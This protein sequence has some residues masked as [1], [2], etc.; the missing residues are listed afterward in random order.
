M[1]PRLSFFNRRN[2]HLWYSW[3]QAKRS[4]LPVSEEV[5][6]KTYD[7]HFATLTKVDPVDFNIM[8]EIFDDPCFKYLL[9]K[10]RKNMMK[11]LDGM[12]PFEEMS[13]SNSACFEQTRGAGGQHSELEELCGRCVNSSLS[14]E[15][16]SM[17][18]D[19]VV[20]SHGK[21]RHNVVREN[22][23]PCGRDEWEELS[24]LAGAW[25]FT[26][27]VNCTIQAVLEPFKVRVIS[28]G[29]A[30]P[31]YSCRPLQKA[32]HGALKRLD[33]FRLIGR[34][35][36]PTDM[37]DLK[38]K[39][40][41]GDQWFS[42]D[43]SAATD[44]LSWIYSGRIL[45]SL[46]KDLPDRDQE[47]A[48]SVLGP[49]ALHYPSRN[50][51]TRVF[52][53]VQ[54]NGQLMGSILSFPILCLANVGV[55]LAVTRDSQRG[56][57]FRD[58]LRHVLVNG[59]DMLYSAHPD[60]WAK[61]VQYGKGVGLEMSVG[62]AYC[63]REY[64]NI[65]STSIHYS[66]ERD[67]DVPFQINYLNSGLFY[68]QHKVQGKIDHRENDGG[69]EGDAELSC[70]HASSD[71]VRYL[72]AQSHHEPG[73]TEGLAVNLNTV[74][75]G[76][77]PGREARLL[78]SFLTTHKD[79]LRKECAIVAK[80]GRKTHLVTRN[81]FLPLSVG[82]MGVNAPKG[83]AFKTT[84]TDQ[85]IAAAVLRQSCA[86]ISA[87]LPL[88]MFDLSKV[89]PTPCAWSKPC[90][91]LDFPSLIMTKEYLSLRTLKFYRT[92]VRR[93]CHT[94]LAVAV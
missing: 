38:E 41:S 37:I 42:V 30:L 59:D 26:K 7:N 47:V 86:P 74:L 28:K 66:L 5:I 40:Q 16:H 90:S 81:L 35:F 82:G 31:Y 72:L 55:Y 71:R 11:L 79:E 91:S 87:G 53:G 85:Q 67:N 2:S 17:S 34:P 13:G 18:C 52:K 6:G 23:I 58:R 46:I 70:R 64:A 21:V 33:P 62:K 25:D 24:S 39:S 9:K 65:N 29:E 8:D 32:L 50:G 43:Y 83:W 75:E 3:F 54:E 51:R 27:P 73:P 14:D 15:L 92:G 77:L 22:R 69:G 57:S 12:A 88:P 89:E 94:R 20:Y 48:L 84:R 1:K 60:L 76:S 10:V 19:P 36:S 49:H 44:G 80:V 68:G 61:H 63:H 93:F 4:A 78:A 45:R 56:W